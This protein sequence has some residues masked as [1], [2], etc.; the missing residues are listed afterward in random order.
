MF[1]Q[2]TERGRRGLTVIELL[3]AIS[4]LAVVVGTLAALAQAVQTA[5][6]YSQCNGGA[7]EEARMVLARITRTAQG[8]HAN[9]RFPGF[10]VVTEQMGPWRFPD[11]LVVWRPLD[12]AAD[13]AGLPRFDEL[14]VYC[15]D[16]EGPERLIELTVPKDHRVVP[17]PEDL[18]A[19]RSAVRA[20]QRAAKSQR[21]E[22]TRLVHTAVVAGSAN[23]SRRAAVRFERRLRPSD[24]EW[25]EYQAGSR[26]WEDLSWA[27]SIYGPQTGLSQ[28]WLRM[29]MQLVPRD[30]TGALRRPIP[31]FG[32]AALYYLVQR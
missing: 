23:S 3:L 4:L 7:V 18:A 5:R 20:M 13:P 1:G 16:P 14:V 11:T 30:T 29:E 28:V 2:T 27:Q 10:L 6:Q 17:P 9:P 8:A 12:E 25:A 26:G 22:L 15:P 24:E 31:F 19:W 21:V 32:S